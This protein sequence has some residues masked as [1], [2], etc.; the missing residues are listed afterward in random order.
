MTEGMP[1]WPIFYKKSVS[2]D[3]TIR[4]ILPLDELTL[5]RPMIPVDIIT[6]VKPIMR[7]NCEGFY[8]DHIFYRLMAQGLKSARHDE[9]DPWKKV[10]IIMPVGVESHYRII[11]RYL[12]ICRHE[13]ANIEFNIPEKRSSLIGLL[14]TVSYCRVDGL[15]EIILES[16]NKSVIGDLNELKALYTYRQN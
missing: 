15:K 14:E 6:L 8:K 7:P 9:D 12:E 11:F 3:G 4:F 13:G 16:L 2:E 5:M 1:S 10:E